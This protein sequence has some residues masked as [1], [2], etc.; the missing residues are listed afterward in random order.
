MFQA[1]Q[2][3]DGL[4]KENAYNLLQ[5]YMMKVGDTFF[6]VVEKKPVNCG[7][8]FQNTFE[9]FFKT[10]F[11]FQLHY[12]KKLIVFFNFFEKYV[13]GLE[14]KRSYV[15]NRQLFDKINNFSIKK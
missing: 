11:V 1:N 7:H 2:D 15:K 13:F 10:F 4:A 5:P 8:D 9:V 6:T 14:D 12:C 3:P